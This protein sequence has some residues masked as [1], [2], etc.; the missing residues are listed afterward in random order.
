MHSTR[1]TRARLLV[2]A[3]VAAVALTAGWLPAAARTAPAAATQRV[4]AGP[5]VNL[6]L[7]GAVATS[8]SAQDAH[9]AGAAID[10]D[11]GTTW[12]AGQWQGALTVQLPHAQVLSGVGV[13]LGDGAGPATATIETATA[14]G[15]W[16]TLPAAR[17]IALSADAP[18]YIAL[19][20]A[21]KLQS[22]RLTVSS[23]DGSWPCV[24]E[25]RLFGRSTA[26]M[27]LGADLSFQRQ[28][29]QAGTRFT[30]AGRAATPV[31]LLSDHGAN[32]VRIRLWVNPP[33]GYSDLA[34]DLALA[35]QVVRA[36]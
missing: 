19:A 36:G 24:G 30:D 4:G 29:L 13:T 20:H 15:G 7:Q 21:T 23:G 11:A 5:T 9:P 33:P 1:R 10:G 12:C 34:D 8:T 2:P 31:Q 27:L 14:A 22:V 18:S 25:L 28:E 6:A 32:Y 35:R 17:S 3:A 16:R 26:P